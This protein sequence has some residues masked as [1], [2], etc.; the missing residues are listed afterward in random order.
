LNRDVIARSALRLLD[1]N[2]IEGVTMRTLA[3]ELGVQA[4]SLYWHVKSKEDIFRAMAAAMSEDA[5]ALMT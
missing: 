1:A 4:P 5:T 2:G 3:A